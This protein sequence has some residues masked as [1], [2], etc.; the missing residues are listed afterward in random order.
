MTN[1]TNRSSSRLTIRAFQTWL[2]GLVDVGATVPA[3]AV[4]ARLP[5]IDHEPA[6]P[7]SGPVP[8]PSW[9]EKLWTCPAET[10]LGLEELCEALSRSSS[11][12]YHRTSIK[13]VNRIP[14]RKLDGVLCF[15]AGAVRAWIRDSEQVVCAGP[16]A[17]S[18]RA[19]EGGR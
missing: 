14:H 10:R 4:L 8:D 11:W 6:P 7:A 12:I 16:M 9:R 2:E 17:S 3:S 18:L 19:I 15:T 1:P 5:E 13:A